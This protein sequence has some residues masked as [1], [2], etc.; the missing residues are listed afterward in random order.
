MCYVQY[1]VYSMMKKITQGFT[2]SVL[3]K[4]SC[5]SQLRMETKMMV[6]QHCVYG[7]ICKGWG[8]LTSSAA[9][10]MGLKSKIRTARAYEGIGKECQRAHDNPK[11][12]CLLGKGAG[13]TSD[14]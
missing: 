4:L 2:L 14:L 13:D 8:C 10:V 11:R 5:H 9:E 6:Q 1:T 3:K 12:H 7:L